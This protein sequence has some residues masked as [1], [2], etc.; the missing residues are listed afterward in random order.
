MAEQLLEKARVRRAELDCPGIATED[1]LE[2]GYD[3][4]SIREIA[5]MLGLTD[6]ACKQTIFRAVKKMRLE[7][8]P[9]VT[10]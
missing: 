5:G 2:H 7:L 3:G 9:L 6:N 10:T 4:A 1:F 8:A